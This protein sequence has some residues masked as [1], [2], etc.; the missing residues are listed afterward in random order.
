MTLRNSGISTNLEVEIKL[1]LSLAKQTHTC[2]RIRMRTQES[3]WDY[4]LH[5]QLDANLLHQD[6]LDLVIVFL[7]SGSF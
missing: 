7:L 1:G 5:I 3:E 4:G 2:V 6:G